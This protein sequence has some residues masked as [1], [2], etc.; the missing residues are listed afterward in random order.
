MRLNQSPDPGFGGI[1]FNTALKLSGIW[2]GIKDSFGGIQFN[3][4]LKQ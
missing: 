2:Q 4:A 1:Q 3:T